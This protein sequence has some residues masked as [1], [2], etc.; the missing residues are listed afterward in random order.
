M[1]QIVVYIATTTREAKRWQR[2]ASA[3]RRQVPGGEELMNEATVEMLQIY[4]EVKQEAVRKGRREGEL[5]G[6]V[7]VI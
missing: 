4:G 2:F 3:V 1:R 6:K 5:R 7:Q